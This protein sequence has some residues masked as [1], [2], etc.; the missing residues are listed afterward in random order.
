MKR[1]VSRWRL[2]AWTGFLVVTAGGTE[3]QTK[4]PPDPGVE[5][6]KLAFLVGKWSCKPNMPRPAPGKTTEQAEDAQ[7][8]REYAWAPGGLSLVMVGYR[9]VQPGSPRLV[10]S[11]VISYDPYDNGYRMWVLG[12]DYRDAPSFSG[13]LAGAKLVLTDEQELKDRQPLMEI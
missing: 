1:R 9:P 12:P 11:D 13:R 3:A 7:V 10:E 8:I 4:S 5:M 6:Q 2:A